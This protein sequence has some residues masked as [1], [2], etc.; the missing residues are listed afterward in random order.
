MKTE[1]IILNNFSPDYPVESLANP[2][3]ILFFDIETTGFLKDEANVYLIGCAYYRDS[4]W[5]IRQF[6][7]SS[8]EEERSL[9]ESFFSFAERFSLL[10]HYNG[11]SFDLPFLKSKA[12]KHGIPYT[13]DGK[14]GI[15]IY[16]RI[17]TYKN[18]LKLPDCKL[19]TVESF[20]GIGR[21]DR[22]NG[23]ELI[24][25]Y[26]DY[27]SSR[28]YNLYQTLLQH[29]SDDIRGM[30]GVISVLAYY[31]LFNMPLTAEGVKSNFYQDINGISRKEI[32]IR[33]RLPHTLP[34]T[35]SF[36]GKACYFKGEK[37]TGTLI[38]PVYDE[39]LKYFYANYK[40]YYYLPLEDTA[41]HKSVASFVDKEFREQAKAEN[42]YTRKI[43]NYL[44]QWSVLVSP[45]F[46]REYDSKDLFFELTDDVKRNRNL[47]SEYAAHVINAIA[48][49]N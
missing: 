5:N 35:I 20:L 9:L 2:S 45:F 39:E 3:D 42:C 25:V 12:E 26:N 21:E 19:K 44:P 22:Y 30:L 10:I 14:Q 17:R 46:K 16:Q 29:N 1:E 38:V 40:D 18:L 37:D 32:V 8:T 15:D 23:G 47:F 27:L 4:N 48:F 28:D 49:Q 33:V 34:K 13:L 41:L 24:A 11:N 6:F 7:A 43:S 31:D 36:M